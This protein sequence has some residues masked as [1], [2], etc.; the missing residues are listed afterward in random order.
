MMSAKES[1]CGDGVGA[2][3]TAVNDAG[4]EGEANRGHRATEAT[5]R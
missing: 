4:G 1:G 5:G 2:G 3:R